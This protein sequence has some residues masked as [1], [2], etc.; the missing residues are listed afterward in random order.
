MPYKSP[1]MTPKA[2]SRERSKQRAAARTRQTLRMPREV[3]SGVVM[4]VGAAI[5]A[6]YRAVASRRTSAAGIAP[7]KM[8]PSEQ[9]RANVDPDKLRAQLAGIERRHS[10]S[11]PSRTPAGSMSKTDAD[12]EKAQK[13]RL[14]PRKPDWSKNATAREDRRRAM[15][16]PTRRGYVQ[17]TSGRAATPKMKTAAKPN[18]DKRLI[19]PKYE[20][21]RASGRQTRA[22]YERSVPKE[23]FKDIAARTEQALRDEARAARQRLVTGPFEKA[24]PKR[25]LGERRTAR[26]T[27][28]AKQISKQQAKRIADAD[29]RDVLTATNRASQEQAGR[30]G[31]GLSD[32]EKMAA[33]RERNANVKPKPKPLSRAQ[34]EANR[35]EA[36]NE[37]I[38]PRPMKKPA[39]GGR[40]R[41]ARGK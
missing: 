15:N 22:E 17:P 5:G 11:K 7:K 18:T 36:S 39:S 21:M 16:S 10:G 34:V 40:K 8:T 41:K 2:A 26:M 24:Y 13:G 28:P 3:Q 32:A 4:P 30:Y 35:L 20:T 29:K 19:A 23:Q 9:R 27:T 14:L 38:R 1:R 25:Y 12:A 31:K 6:I 37:R 33:R